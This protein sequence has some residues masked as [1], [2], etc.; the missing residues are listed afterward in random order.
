[1]ERNVRGLYPRLPCDR[2]RAVVRH[3]PPSITMVRCGECGNCLA[4]LDFRAKNKGNSN[5][6]K[7]KR[8]ENKNACENPTAAKRARISEAERLIAAG[9]GGEI[10]GE[11][12]SLPSG[13]EAALDPAAHEAHPKGSL[14][15]EEYFDQKAFNEYGALVRKCTETTKDSPSAN[16]KLEAH[17]MI[18]KM[19][20]L[21]DPSMKGVV[22][23]EEA[24]KDISNIL[25]KW[26]SKGGRRHE[27]IHP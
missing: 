15:E 27:G 11:Y 22:D 1:M 19:R 8:F 26:E 17:T 16:V 25:A 2:P 23:Y 14:K 13:E 24:T 10:R 21:L 6:K 9:H 18:R 3:G 4:V 5:R 7:V 20:G 12:R